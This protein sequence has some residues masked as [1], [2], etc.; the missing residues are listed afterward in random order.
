MPHSIIIHQTY[1]DVIIALCKQDTIVAQKI[2]SNKDISKLCVLTIDDL[3]SEQS[4]Q[5][6]HISYIGANTGPGPFSTVRSIIANVNGLHLATRIPLISIDGLQTLFGEHDKQ[7]ENRS[8]IA[9]L[10]AYNNEVYFAFKHNGCHESGYANIDNLLERFQKIYK[11]KELLFIGNGSILHERKITDV[12]E[13]N[14]TVANDKQHASIEYI[15]MRT[16]ADSQTQDYKTY[17]SAEYV[18]I[19][20]GLTS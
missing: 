15:V 20:S 13:S 19:Y 17:L 7:N 1:T 4:L 14:T 5:L 8:V 18:K 6:A 3:L 9:L 11:N 10:N 16:Y 2:I 12:F